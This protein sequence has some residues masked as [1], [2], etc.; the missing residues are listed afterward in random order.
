MSNQLLHADLVRAIIGAFYE[1]CNY[2]GY[3]LTERVYCGALAHELRDRGHTVVREL[4]IEVRYKEQ[5]IA[6]QRLDM[7]IDDKIIIENKSTE[8]L[9]PADRMQL[10]SYLRA[11]NLEVGLLLHFGPTAKFE[12]FIDHPKRQPSKSSCTPTRA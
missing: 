2:F 10:V 9:S 4:M 3:G 7:V 8:K 5:V 12:R 11:T 1:V 6:K